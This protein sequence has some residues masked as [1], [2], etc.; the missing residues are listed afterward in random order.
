MIKKIIELKN[1]GRFVNF[2][3]MQDFAIRVKERPNNC[4]IIF[5][6][7]GS[8]KSTISNVLS[9][10]GDGSFSKNKPAVLHAITRDETVMPSIKLELQNGQQL[11]Y[12]DTTSPKPIYVFNSNFVSE[13][14]S[15]GV[16]KF[17]GAN[18]G[19]TTP[20]LQDINNKIEELE[21]NKRD[22]GKEIERLQKEFE[23]IKRAASNDFNKKFPSLRLTGLTLDNTSIPQTTEIELEKQKDNL[24]L[25]YE[26]STKS[27]EIANHI[28]QLQS[29]SLNQINLDI[30]T[31]NDLLGRTI[32]QLSK[33]A[34]EDRIQ[35]IKN[36]FT[37]SE[38]GAFVE[39]W[40][41][42]GK[43]ILEKPGMTH[44]PI[45]NSDLTG[46][47]ET[48]LQD[49][50][51][52]FD[53]KYDEFITMI[54]GHIASL[55]TISAE[56]QSVD[57]NVNAIEALYSKYKDI[58]PELQYVKPD[59]VG[60]RKA[61]NIIKT[62]L[63]NKLQNISLTDTVSA[64]AFDCLIQ[65]NSNITSI[66]SLKTELLKKLQSIAPRKSDAI[67][68]DI[69]R[70][71]KDLAII[72]FNQLD[73][74]SNMLEIYNTK[75]QELD[76]I[77]TTDANDDKGLLYWNNKRVMELSKI[78]AESAG[79]NKFLK[80][81][82]IDTFTIDLRDKPGEETKDIIVKYV[83]SKSEKRKQCL[84]DGEKTA[85]GFAYFLSKFEN[86]LD[87]TS[88]TNAIVVIDDPISSLDENR[89]YST[90]H[91][92]KDMFEKTKQLI[93]LSH[94]FLFLKFFNAVYPGNPQQF[95]INKDS[96]GSLP[97]ELA[98]FETTYF[99]MLKDIQKFNNSDIEYKDTRKYLPNFIRRVLET[100]FAFK[101]AMLWARNDKN[102]RSPGLK[103][104]RDYM[105]DCNYDKN[106]IDKLDKIIDITDKQ[107]HGSAQTL[108]DNNSYIS[109]DDLKQIAKNAIEIIEIMDNSHLQSIK[110]F[111]GAEQDNALTQ[112]EKADIEEGRALKVPENS[113]N[114]KI[115]NTDF[116]P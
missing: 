56:L 105:K 23:K 18:D 53:K 99:Y 92:I 70:V 75:K 100:F 31:T 9:L 1:I 84:S 32:T 72:E 86:E 64:G 95:F 63:E 65:F 93:V 68:T 11:A 27:V 52:Y 4:N 50:D 94:N 62:C 8:G 35:N 101:F 78:K 102:K 20:E 45:C 55:N 13:H 103:D 10:F 17:N 106:L 115:A 33:S 88:K 79:I 97:D 90:A 51:G 54:S 59:V 5:G 69:K 81:M 44:C 6:F 116:I 91:L 46:Q 38:S 49:F 111:G 82:G 37:N 42:H 15:N 73:S 28:T 47:L 98:N 110:K 43:Q 114:I 83:I 21:K 26:H 89:L 25:E 2:Q 34:L 12:S 71:Y 80:N 76:H 41:R 96:L 22:A 39:E 16:R 77:D 14:V 30:K 57:G 74:D 3:Q 24:I 108:T 29:I 7:N 67:V 61:L 104:A 112:K 66:I 58:L 60:V 40:F 85:L 48:I 113:T 36:K 19:L 107:C 109:E 87:E